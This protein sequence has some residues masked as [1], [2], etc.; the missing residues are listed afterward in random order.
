M[1]L[2]QTDLGAC[3]GGTTVTLGNRLDGDAVEP[4]IRLHQRGD[5]LGTIEATNFSIGMA[6]V[7]SRFA[8]SHQSVAE[9]T[10]PKIE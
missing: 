6:G 9:A 2:R 8:P 1:W 4:G 10:A 7:S 5:D 3:P